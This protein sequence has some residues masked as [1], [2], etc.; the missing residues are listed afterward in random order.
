M[1]KKMS[2]TKLPHRRIVPRYALDFV[3]PTYIKVLKI[4]LSNPMQQFHEREVARK[5]VVSSGSANKM[6]RMMARSDILTRQS[7]GQMV[8]YSLNLSNPTARQF[9][10]LANVSSLEGLL[11]NL[12]PIS[13]RVILFGSCS[14]GTDTR[15]SDID[16]M[17]LTDEQQST[18]REISR[19]NSKA[20]RQVTPI[21]VGANDFAR[22]GREDKPLYDNIE[23]GIVLWESQ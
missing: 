17:I 13:K 12:R 10:I 3:T 16:I 14:E 5:A 15:E 20:E 11:A 18:R 19:F 23:R 6:L 22:L 9:K 2:D 4:F 1:L 21:I 8:L 7:R